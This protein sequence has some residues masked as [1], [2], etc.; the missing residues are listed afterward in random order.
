VNLGLGSPKKTSSL[1]EQKIKK[2]L[3]LKLKALREANKGKDSRVTLVYV[4]ELT[5]KE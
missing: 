2:T 3:F 1:T 4:Y 5:E